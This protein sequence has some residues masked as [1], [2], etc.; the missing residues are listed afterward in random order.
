MSTNDQ[1]NAPL[2]PDDHPVDPKL[3][4]IDYSEE[5]NVS[6]IH[7]S[8]LREKVEPRE[9]MEPV[10]LWMIG[11][12][13][14]TILAG[15]IYLGMYSGGFRADVYDERPGGFSAQ[16]SKGK[17]G[18]PNQA[19]AVAA[20]DPAADL[21]KI[22][23][24]QYNNNCMACHQATGLGVA[25]QYPPLV[26]SDYVLGPERRLISVVL[27]G[28][29]GPLTVQGCAFN[30]PMAVWGKTMNDKQIAAVL[31]YI[32]QEWGNSA[33]PLSPEQV[34]AVRKENESR[35]KC[36]SE[37]ELKALSDTPVPGAGAA[38]TPAPAAVTT[39][40]PAAAPASAPQKK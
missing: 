33:P 25:G 29:E 6:R 24:R 10:P 36:W 22:G 37:A 12:I 15:G 32:R 21:L 3:Q 40:P 31:T 18:G 7:E 9:G 13:M 1:S 8:I 39:A 17:G 30:G 34:Q 20:T 5:T 26:K 2:H 16:E 27:N 28:L 35:S 19:G 23:K 11:V 4:G 14:G 38:P